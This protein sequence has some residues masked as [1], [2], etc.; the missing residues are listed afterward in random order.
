MCEHWA[1][2]GTQWTQKHPPISVMEVIECP[3][4]DPLPLERAKV[5]EMAMKHSWQR[6]R[7]GGH[8]KVEATMPAWFDQDGNKRKRT[9]AKAKQTVVTGG[10]ED[11]LLCRFINPPEEPDESGDNEGVATTITVLDPR[12]VS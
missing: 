3:G 2:Q 12:R 1:G 4:G 11:G 9:D 6:V 5:A 7:G 10:E 8:I